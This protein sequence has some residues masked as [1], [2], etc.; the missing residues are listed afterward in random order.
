MPV[1]L[2]DYR[3]S[4]PSNRGGAGVLP[5]GVLLPAPIPMGTPLVLADLGIFMSAGP[6]NRVDLHLFVGIGST[7]ST[8]FASF[9]FQFL[10]DGTPFWQSF[11][12]VDADS[13]TLT[14]G[15]STINFHAGDFNVPVGFHVY[16]AQISSFGPGS[17]VV[18]GPVTF[19]G[20][21]YSLT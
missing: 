8:L 7:S 10:R 14:A 12:G 16:T 15:L 21:A 13:G 17:A 19:S 20:T 4:Q 6:V 1:T 18:G 5:N 9:L 3:I 11:P 2:I